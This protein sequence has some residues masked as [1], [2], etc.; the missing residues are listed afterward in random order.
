M[1]LRVLSYTL[2]LL[3][4][5]ITVKCGS[6]TVKV[7][8]SKGLPDEVSPS[9]NSS[10]ANQTEIQNAEGIM[11]NIT[12]TETTTVGVPQPLPEILVA[13]KFSSKRWFD[14]TDRRTKE[15]KDP[16]FFSA[17]VYPLSDGTSL[18]DSDQG[19]L[20]DLCEMLAIA[21]RCILRYPKQGRCSDGC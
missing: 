5:A 18:V 11:S 1:E 21:M 13:R 14:I 2:L 4:F 19:N 12:T 15:V 7:K 16:G 3:S 9:K 10:V 6:K 20:F 17:A 8:P